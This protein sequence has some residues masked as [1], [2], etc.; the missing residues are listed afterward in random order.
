MGEIEGKLSVY[1]VDPR[2]DVKKLELRLKAAEDT[3]RMSLESEKIEEGSLLLLEKDGSYSALAMA[4][5][6]A[7][8]LEAET[9]REKLRMDAIRLL[10]GTVAACRT[11]TLAGVTAPVES[12]VTR[13]LMRIAG[14]RFGRVRLGETFEPVHVV[15]RETENINATPGDLS[16]GEQEQL[17]FVTRLALAEVL[18]RDERQ[19][20]VLDDVLAFTDSG[21]LNRA[22]AIL[23]EAAQRNQV[24][25][26]TCR[27]EWYRGI[28]SASFID[29]EAIVNARR[30]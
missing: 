19:L 29:L 28:P 7:T 9:A 24:V 11:E 1:G 2:E 13:N 23:E 25:V 16:G 5:E 18:S 27:P 8:R 17:Y 20:V 22:L 21:R 15:P 6:K 14:P 12:I 26:L 3:A 10:H 4:E 30:E